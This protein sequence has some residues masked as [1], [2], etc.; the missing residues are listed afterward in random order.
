MTSAN[1]ESS[2]VEIVEKAARSGNSAAAL[3]H[4]RTLLAG[5]ALT[6]DPVLAMRFFR[7][8]AEQG[9]VESMFELGC[10]QL[11]GRG[12]S[13]NVSDACE[14]LARASS[15]GHVQAAKK[16]AEHFMRSDQEGDHLEKAADYWA[17]AARNALAT[18]DLRFRQLAGECL[19]ELSILTRS[20]EIDAS[21][22]GDEKELLKAAA[23]MGYA[24]ASYELALRYMEAQD[25][26]ER[27]GW[28]SAYLYDAAR[29]GVQQ[30]SE[31]IRE[32]SF[33]PPATATDRQPLH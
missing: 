1:Y 19:H 25:G 12:V 3:R 24:R 27:Q 33:S 6:Y 20:G 23:D 4:A 2:T 22:H 28:A 16:L 10:L 26:R 31:K 14:W 15:K 29:G 17:E 9:V 32:L 13:K 5:E 8:A 30:A 7:I 18:G 11:F 21:K